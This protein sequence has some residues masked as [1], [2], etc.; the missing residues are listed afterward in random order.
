[1]RPGNYASTETL[2]PRRKARSGSKGKSRNVWKGKGAGALR[3]LRPLF[4][5]AVKF[6]RLLGSIWREIRAITESWQEVSHKFTVESC[7]QL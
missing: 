2:K 5:C 6:L 3:F 4:D 1:M 7:A